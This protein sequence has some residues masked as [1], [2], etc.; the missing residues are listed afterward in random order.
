MKAVRSPPR[1]SPRA[2]TC[3]SLRPRSRRS[4]TRPPLR[5]ARPRRTRGRPDRHSQTRQNPIEPRPQAK[6][7]ETAADAW[8]SAGDS[9]CFGTMPAL[10]SSMKLAKMTFDHRHDERDEGVP[11][12]PDHR[13]DLHQVAEHGDA[14]QLRRDERRLEMG[15][16]CL[17]QN[18]GR[19]ELPDQE[20]AQR[21]GCPPVHRERTNLK[22]ASRVCSSRA[23]SG[24]GRRSAR[25]P[26]Q[27]RGC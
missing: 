20:F 4:S 13:G 11:A 27:A 12:R 23:W 16:A 9:T 19:T 24:T 17:D 3:Q 8:H 2:T 14:D 1:G 7:N 6:A 21:R 5:A 26:W 18:P 25:R 10:G 15:V 22:T